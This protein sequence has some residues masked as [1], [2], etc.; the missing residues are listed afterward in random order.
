MLPPSHACSYLRR[1]LSVTN[2]LYRVTGMQLALRLLLLLEFVCQVVI[3][4]AVKCV[5][6]ARGITKHAERRYYY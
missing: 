2:R 1:E 4:S 5:H 6:P 3:V